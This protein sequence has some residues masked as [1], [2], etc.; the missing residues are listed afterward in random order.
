MKSG[1]GGQISRHWH[2]GNKSVEQGEGI[3]VACLILGIVEIACHPVV[4]A[5]MRIS[6]LFELFHPFSACLAGEI[7]AFDLSFGNV[8]I[9]ANSVRQT[10]FRHFLEYPGLHFFGLCEIGLLCIIIQ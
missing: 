2:Y 6:S 9:Q 5:T 4:F 7:D 1:I 3:G 8:H 10:K